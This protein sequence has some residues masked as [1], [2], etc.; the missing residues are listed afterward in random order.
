MPAVGELERESVTLIVPRHCYADRMPAVEPAFADDMQF[1][2][3]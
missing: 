2:M 1:A 3:K